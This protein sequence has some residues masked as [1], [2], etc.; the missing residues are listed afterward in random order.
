GAHRRPAG[1]AP[2]RRMGLPPAPPAGPLRPRAPRLGDDAAA[3]GGQRVPAR[4]PALCRTGAAGLVLAHAHRLPLHPADEALRGAEPATAEPHHPDRAH[5]PAGPLRVVREP[6]RPRPR[7]RR[8]LVP[9][10]P[11]GPGTGRRRPLRGGHAGVRPPGGQHGR[12][13]L[14]AAGIHPE[15]TGRENVYLNGSILGLRRTE[16]ERIFDDIVGFA[17]LEQFIDTPVK[18][19]SSGMYIRLGFAVAINVDPEILLVDEVLSVGDESFQRKCLDKVRA[20]QEEGR[21]IVVVT[22]NAD[23]VRVMCHRGAAL[24]HGRLV[25]VG[26]PNE[27]IRTFRER[28]LQASISTADLDP[29]L[30]RPELS[31]VWEK[32][33][34]AEAE[35]VYASLDSPQ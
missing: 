4:H 34:I 30:E 1:A 13:A 5:L 24:H 23:L 9:A 28:L 33:R 8:G 17:G 6:A 20:F 22:H 7:A 19:Y 25:A 10:Q 14:M 15:L 26:E 32:V 29:S 21:T 16:V 2:S 3:V 31:P 12:G 35:I 11:P 18:F 27:V